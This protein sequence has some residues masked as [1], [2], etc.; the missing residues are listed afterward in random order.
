MI[1]RRGFLIGTAAAA[2]TPAIPAAA[3]AP[4]AA[5]ETEPDAWEKRL[6][7]IENLTRILRKSRAMMEALDHHPGMSERSRRNV[8]YL[9]ALTIDHCARV[10]QQL[11]LESQ[12]D[13]QLTMED[14]F[15]KT[16]RDRMGRFAN[17]PHPRDRHM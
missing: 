6:R 16:G 3:A 10:T 7:E 12:W 15:V 11:A 4:A 5:V 13:A 2:T 14:A 8:Q 1:D 17:L 9:H